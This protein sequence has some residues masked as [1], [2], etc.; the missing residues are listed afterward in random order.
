M[1]TPPYRELRGLLFAYDGKDQESTSEDVNFYYAM[2]MWGKATGNEEMS[3]LGR[4][5]LGL[6][7]RSISTYFLMTNDNVVH[8]AAFVR[9]KVGCGSE[10]MCAT[11]IYRPFCRNDQGVAMENT[12]LKERQPLTTFHSCQQL[13]Y[14]HHL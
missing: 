4:L 10:D 3:R 9:N 5:Q 1:N 13:P 7:A 6:L 8:P 2:A 11:G 14:H 12:D